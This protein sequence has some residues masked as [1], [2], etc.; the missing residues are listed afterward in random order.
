VKTDS[1]SRERESAHTPSNLNGSEE[2]A[3]LVRDEQEHAS[4]EENN[5]NLANC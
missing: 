3:D 5:N 2:L 1:F 4:D